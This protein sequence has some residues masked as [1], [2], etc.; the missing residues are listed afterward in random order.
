MI[1]LNGDTGITT[2]GLINT[3][4]TTL[5]NLT[6]TGN[7][8]LGDQS[9]DTLNVANGNLVLNSSGNVG[10]GTASP[11]AKLQVSGIIRTTADVNGYI[12]VGRFSSAF[13]GSAVNGTGFLQLQV[14]GSGVL[15]LDSSGNA[16][17]GITTT[18]NT[19]GRTL[20]VGQAA[21]WTSE[22]GSNRWW[23]GSNWYFNSGDKYINNGFAT[24]Y[25]QQVGTHIWFTSPSGTAGN[26]ISFTQA[27]TLDASGNLKVNP[28]NIYTDATSGIFFTGTVGSFTNG[29]FG[30]GTNNV[31]INAGGSERVRIDSSGNMGIGGAAPGGFRLYTAGGR[32]NFNSSD[33]Y[34]IRIGN[35][36]TYGAYIGSSAEDTLN[37][38][39]SVGNE[40]AR[41]NSSG[42]FL[43]G[44]TSNPGS[45][46]ME[47]YG[48]AHFGLGSENRG[49]YLGP[50]GF[51]AS[52]RYNGDGSLD[53][54]PRSGYS[55]KF[56]SETGGTER[57]RIDSS[58]RLIVGATSNTSSGDAVIAAGPGAVMI[59]RQRTL[60]SG[61]TMDITVGTSNI[62]YWSGFL[63]VLN[64]DTSNGAF[65]TQTNF[66][67]CAENQ[68]QNFFTAV[69]QTVN[70]AG[71]ARSFTITY[72]DDGIIRMTNTSGA[73]CVC[74]MSFFGG[75]ANLN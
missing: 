59:F 61:A 55:I 3:G 18:N 33:Q 7:T 16:G 67:I 44:T 19:L 10:I 66:S 73:T 37:F 71:G 35:N 27:M 63:C 58:G 2:P 20:Q 56:L 49:I 24:L 39:D 32:V 74:T 17:L 68:S 11:G 52:L 34:A 45:Y 6:T 12:D 15:N 23:L 65:R 25:S 51:T 29:I 28:G 72:V 36:G 60:A 57:A 1:T 53:I 14:N 31:A 48:D 50:N 40:R 69:L 46:R 54:A 41:I 26:A 70:G 21:T 62:T 4:S 64:S 42:N 43:L 5:I 75:G 9:T 13:G 47:V 38:Y 22:S 8:I 30:V